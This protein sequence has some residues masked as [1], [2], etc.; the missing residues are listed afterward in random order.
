MGRVE[1]EGAGGAVVAGDAE[2]G[3]RA[4]PWL[5]NPNTSGGYAACTCWFRV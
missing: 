5:P 2:V 4:Y 1:I 3:A